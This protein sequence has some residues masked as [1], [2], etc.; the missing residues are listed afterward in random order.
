MTIRKLDLS[1][2]ATQVP[3]KSSATHNYTN[4]RWAQ[5]GRVVTIQ[6]SAQCVYDKTTTDGSIQFAV[7]GLPGAI[8][9]IP[10]FRLDD[11]SSFYVT[12]GN[13]GLMGSQNAGTIAVVR[14]VYIAADE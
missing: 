12:S 14:I 7:E 5:Y 8:D 2:S 10:Y 4:I 3:A 9:G 11:G 6:F 13:V 1:A